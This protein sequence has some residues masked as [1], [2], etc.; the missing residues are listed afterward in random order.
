MLFVVSMTKFEGPRQTRSRTLSS[1]TRSAGTAR[2]PA[3][4]VKAANRLENATIL[5][6][7]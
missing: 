7:L 4:A 2:E 6:C 1:L 5:T 3:M